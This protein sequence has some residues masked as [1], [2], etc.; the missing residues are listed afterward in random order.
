MWKAKL[1]FFTLQF[2]ILSFITHTN[3][4]VDT[5]NIKIAKHIQYDIPFKYPKKIIY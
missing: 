5:K 3:K 2:K 1:N 4:H